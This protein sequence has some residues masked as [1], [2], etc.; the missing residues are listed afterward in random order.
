LKTALHVIAMC[1]RL[2]VYVV[3]DPAPV[4]PDGLPRVAYGVDVLTPNQLEAEAMLRLKSTR[5][6]M[7]KRVADPKQIASRL[8]DFGSKAVVLKRG[9]RGA[10]MLARDGAIRSIRPVKVKVVDTTAAGDAFTAA[11]AVGHSEGMDLSEAVHFANA[12]GAACCGG[13]GA[14]PALPTR[15]A[16]EALLNP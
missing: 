14:Q 2:G 5:D 10:V 16:V 7:P 3:L 4:P 11:L 9:A 1:Q 13:F 8:L 12:A 15:D 6:A